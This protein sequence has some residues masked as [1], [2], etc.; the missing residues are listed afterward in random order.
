MNEEKAMEE[1]KE[2]EP[3]TEIGPEEV[4]AVTSPLGS[5]KNKNNFH[6]QKAFRNSNNSNMR[7]SKGATSQLPNDIKNANRSAGLHPIAD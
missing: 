2:E 6:L 1:P 7:R 4:K 3:K 5:A